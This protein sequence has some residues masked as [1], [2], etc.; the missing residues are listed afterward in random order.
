MTYSVVNVLQDGRVFDISQLV[1]SIRW[2]GDVRQA[3]R[4]LDLDMV[5]SSDENIPRYNVPLASVIIL[6]N[7]DK[8]IIR[9]VVFDVEKDTDGTCQVTA[10]EHSI[11]LLKSKHTAV[12]RGMTATGIIKNLCSGFGVAT[13]EMIETGVVLEKLILRNQ[14]IWDMC[15]TA[16]TDTSKRNGKK[17]QLVMNEGKLSIWQKGAQ[18]V[19]WSIAAG[20]DL[21]SATYS[22]NIEEM[23]NRIIIMGD[24]DKVLAEVKDAA[25]IKQYGLLSDLQQEGNIKAAE[26]Q[27]M[28]QNLLKELGKVNREASIESLGIDEVRPGVAIWVTEPLTGITGVFYVDTDEHRIENGLHTMRLKLN[29]TDE[30]AVKETEKD[31]GQ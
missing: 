13:G 16:L 4:K 31:A 6:R 7:G 15:I 19:R 30:V 27:Q 2:G 12:Y 28:A 17:Y 10:Y 29:W 9:G 8:E 11:Y 25:L 1:K 18:G 24:K 23:K 3:A 20:A 14:T 21:M 26:A 5:Y 22:E